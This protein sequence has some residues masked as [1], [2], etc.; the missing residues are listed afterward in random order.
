MYLKSGVVLFA[1]ACALAAPSLAKAHAGKP[2]LAR[3]DPGGRDVG[4]ELRLHILDF[5]KAIPSL[6]GFS[7]DS[8]QQDIDSIKSDLLAYAGRHFLVFRDGQRCGPR[9]SL[10]RM[11][12]NG[13]VRVHGDYQCPVGGAIQVQSS[14][15]VEIEAQHRTLVQVVV[16]PGQLETL[17]LSPARPRQ[18]VRGLGEGSIAG[19][20]WHFIVDG[21]THI[22]SGADHV[23][24]VL[25]LVIIAAGRRRHLLW[26]IT[27]FTAAHTLTLVLAAL[28]KVAVDPLVVEPI[29]GASIAWLAYEYASQVRRWRPASSLLLVCHGGFAVAAITGAVAFP[30]SGA[31]GL[32]LLAV[33][34]DQVLGHTQDSGWIRAGLF[35]FLFGLVHGLGFAGPLL[36]LQTGGWHLFAT[37]FGFNLGVELGQLAVVGSLLAGGAVMRLIGK[38]D[39]IG[40]LL[41]PAAWLL[42]ATGA[43][44]FVARGL[45]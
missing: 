18:A 11:D 36:D 21:V 29:I 38:G 44:W 41:D 17:M 42:A 24:F 34:Y 19:S 4:V 45:G 12:R 35:P 1:I 10:G 8:S 30:V 40:R 9:L 22:L 37:V 27:G 6:A 2:S 33:G 3:L 13:M 5:R 32:L 28:D 20:L 14:L 7:P 39:S 25:G 16:A 15:F 43:W 23:L 31:V 26:A